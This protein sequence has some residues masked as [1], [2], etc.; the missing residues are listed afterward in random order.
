MNKKNKEYKYKRIY[1]KGG[2]FFSCLLIGGFGY[3]SKAEKKNRCQ[4]FAFDFIFR[5]KNQ[6]DIRKKIRKTA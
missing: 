5:Q 2:Y 1:E 6:S 4:A 3:D